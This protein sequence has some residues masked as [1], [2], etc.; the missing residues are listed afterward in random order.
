MVW[1]NDF[2]SEYP[3]EKVNLSPSSLQFLIHIVYQMREIVVPTKINNITPLFELPKGNMWLSIPPELRINIETLSPF[4]KFSFIIHHRSFDIYMTGVSLKNQNKYLKWIYKWFSFVVPYCPPNCSPHL[5]VYLYFLGEKKSLPQSGEII[6]VIHA[7]SAFTTSC[8]GSQDSG[9]R[10]SEI[11]IFRKEEWFKVLIHESFHVLGLDFSGAS[12]K[13][14]NKFIENNIFYVPN[15]DFR[16]YETYC[17]TCANIL[18]V[19][20]IVSQNRALTTIPLIKKQIREHLSLE[21]TFSLFQWAKI[22][23]YNN[24]DYRELQTDNHYSEKKSVLS[25]YALKSVSLYFSNDFIERYWLQ[26]EN[27]FFFPKTRENMGKYCVFFKERAFKQDYVNSLERYGDKIEKRRENKEKSVLY[28]TL[29][30]TI[31]DEN[32][33]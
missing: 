10:S 7:N 2:I 29:R 22:L 28:K 17:E 25:Y 1:K 13:E 30:M 26:K 24:M 14:V 16:L 3:L 12:T 11:V 19:L 20:F 27:P 6:D 9:L 5:N 21:K 18:N 33:L 4:V 8:S 23:N 32:N 15:H 31:I